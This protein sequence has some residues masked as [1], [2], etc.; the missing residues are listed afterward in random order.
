MLAAGFSATE[1][2]LLSTSPLRPRRLIEPL[3][4]EEEGMN[5]R[6]EVAGS[7]GF[8]PVFDAMYGKSRSG[9]LSVRILTKTRRRLLNSRGPTGKF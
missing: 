6:S 1:K 5:S 3:Q 7:A 9:I 8:K 2:A 4:K